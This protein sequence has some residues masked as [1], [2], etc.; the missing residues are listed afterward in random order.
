MFIFIGAAA[1]ESEKTALKQVVDS[2]TQLK[3]QTSIKNDQLK[4]SK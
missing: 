3:K 4:F 2:Q 1:A